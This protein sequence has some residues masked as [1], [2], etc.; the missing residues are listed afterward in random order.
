[1]SWDVFHEYLQ[2]KDTLKPES[3]LCDE[4]MPE[5]FNAPADNNAEYMA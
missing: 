4:L 1:M 2:V 3:G 5:R